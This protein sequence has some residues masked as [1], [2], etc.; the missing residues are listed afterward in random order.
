MDADIAGA[1]LGDVAQGAGRAVQ[2]RLGAQ[3][4]HLGVRRRLRRQV[5]AGAEAQLHPSVPH[6]RH[7]RG[8]IERAG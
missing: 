7:Q 5:F 6:A 3:E 2:E 1:G 8:R 4:Q